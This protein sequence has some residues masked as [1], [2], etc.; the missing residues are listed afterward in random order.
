M[1]D[2]DALSF[3]GACQRGFRAVCLL[4]TSSFMIV[5]LKVLK[6]GLKY[7]N[8]SINCTVELYEAIKE[9]CR[10]ERAKTRMQM[11]G[12]LSLGSN[13]RQQ[14]RHPSNSYLLYLHAYGSASGKV[15]VNRYASTRHLKLP[16]LETLGGKQGYVF[17]EPQRN[18]D[19]FVLSFLSSS[20]ASWNLVLSNMVPPASS[21]K[22][23]STFQSSF[24]VLFVAPPTKW[25]MVERAMSHDCD[26]LGPFESLRPCVA[27]SLPHRQVY[28]CHPELS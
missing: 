14:S 13:T 2:Y 25:E 22:G 7:G 4:F 19:M 28:G 20:A 27:L 18:S 6:Y 5:T 3:H 15:L 10:F 24:R 12:R 1:P 26:T 11:L 17:N 8:G 23:E 9:V 21:K 16:S